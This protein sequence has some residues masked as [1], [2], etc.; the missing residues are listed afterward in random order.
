[1]FNLSN[2]FLLTSCQGFTTPLLSSNP[3]KEISH[4]EAAI[5]TNQF[6]QSTSTPPGRT[7]PPPSPK[8]CASLEPADLFSDPDPA[9]EITAKLSRGRC[10]DIVRF[11]RNTRWVYVSNQK[12]EGWVSLENI[13]VTGDLHD[14]PL[15]TPSPSF[16]PKIK[17]EI[18]T[19]SSFPKEDPGLTDSDYHQT[20]QFEYNC[21]TVELNLPIKQELDQYFSVQDKTYY[22]K[23]ELP[24][25]WLDSYYRSFLVSS[26]DQE[27]IQFTIDQ[28]QKE[29]GAKTGDELIS[30]LIR[31]TQHLEYDCNKYFSYAYLAD[32]DY[33]TSF[34]YET[35]ADQKGVCGDFSL[36]MVKFFKELGYG[37]A[38]LLY[39]QVNHMAAGIQ[40]P[41]ETAS[42][43]IGDTGYCYIETTTPARI[44]HKPEVINGT[45]FIEEPYIIPISNGN[46]FSLMVDLKTIMDQESEEYGSDILDLV[47]C[48]EIE[49]YKLIQNQESSLLHLEREISSLDQRLDNMEPKIDNKEASYQN[50]DCEGTLPQ[51]KYEECKRKYNTL[52]ALIDDYNQVVDKRN[53]LRADY[54][55]LYNK[56]QK[57]ISRLNQRL[58]SKQTGCSTLSYQSLDTNNN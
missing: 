12:G 7:Q 37:S 2:L 14:L 42:Y 33:D 44:G 30:A 6:Q 53:N 13:N 35:L 26:L 11:D 25:N 31:F 5:P 43:M 46:T 36:L 52:L 4:L 58:D 24:E 8:G 55:S 45:D 50:S 9:S 18:Q 20:Y 10:A 51:E 17:V 28:I 3:A 40:C 16:V 32:D 23:G 29:T 19:P 22:Y 38:L 48:T 34:P 15:Y 49:L 47:N 21:Q 54:T 27:A 1:L 56:Y 39:D 57:N 41:L